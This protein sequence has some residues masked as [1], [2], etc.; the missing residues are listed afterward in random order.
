MQLF[1][2]FYGVLF[3]G[4]LENMGYYDKAATYSGMQATCYDIG[5]KVAV[6]NRN[7]WPPWIV[8]GGRHES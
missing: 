2:L 5:L 3:S 1:Q 7:G 8:T 4:L 6:M